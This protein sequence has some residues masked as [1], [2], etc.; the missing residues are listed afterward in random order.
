MFKNVEGPVE[1]PAIHPLGQHIV[2]KQD[3]PLVAPHQKSD[4]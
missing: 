2:G 3:L 4:F 1:N